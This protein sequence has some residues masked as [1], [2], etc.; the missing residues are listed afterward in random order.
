MYWLGKHIDFGDKF[1]DGL[2]DARGGAKG[3]DAF[4]VFLC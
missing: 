2:S 3:K 4:G 1:A